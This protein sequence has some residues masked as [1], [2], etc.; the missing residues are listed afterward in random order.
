M[1]I[2]G[3]NWGAMWL[4]GLSRRLICMSFSPRCSRPTS[5]GPLLHVIP[6]LLLTILSKKGK[7][8]QKICLN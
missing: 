5:C 1:K 8:G 7:K 4:G 3:I 6:P 2:F